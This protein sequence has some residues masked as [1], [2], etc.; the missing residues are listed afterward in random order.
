MKTDLQFKKKYRWKFSAEFVGTKLA[1]RWVKITERPTLH[2]VEKE[3]SDGS[4]RIEKQS[5]APLVITFYDPGTSG[6]GPK[7]DLSDLY[8]LLAGFY[9][10]V[11]VS[12][13][14]MTLPKS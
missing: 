3:N 10:F 13:K 1:E 8:A 2:I 12:S 4:F 11:L 9:D 6:N 5:W 14:Q 7:E